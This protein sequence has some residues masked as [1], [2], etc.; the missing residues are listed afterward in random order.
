MK[1]T[2]GAAATFTMLQQRKVRGA[3]DKIVI[4]VMGLG[5]RGT[6]LAESFAQRPDAEIAYLCDTDT[7]NTSHEPCGYKRYELA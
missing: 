4:G 7:K 6:Y 5:G 3:N 2:V 1:G